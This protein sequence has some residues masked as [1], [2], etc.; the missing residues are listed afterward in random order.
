MASIFDEYDLEDI[1]KAIS[2]AE[3]GGEKNPWIRTNSI[4]KSG[5]GSTA[6]GPV[7]ITGSLLDDYYN[8]PTKRSIYD[9]HS[10]VADK[11]REQAN[12]FN[13]YGNESE[14]KPLHPKHASLFALPYRGIMAVN[15]FFGGEG[16][17]EA[18]DY[19]GE[20]SRMHSG[21]QDEYKA[22]ALDLMQD[23]WNDNKNKKEPFKEFLIDWR[24][25]EDEDYLQKVNK[26]LGR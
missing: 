6:Y 24:G 25:E 16:I 26:Y 14:D 13:Y 18:Y 8:H 2:F 9:E 10:N 22:L 7:Q 19:G 15:D 4:P 20:G 12:L 21:L 17:R 3:T 23:M 1:Y 11:L 5:K